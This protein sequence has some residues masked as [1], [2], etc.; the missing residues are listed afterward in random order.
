MGPEG[1]QK[2]AKSVLPKNRKPSPLPKFN[3]DTTEGPVL[4]I[5]HGANTLCQSIG[6]LLCAYCLIDILPF[7]PTSFVSFVRLQFL[8]M[9]AWPDS[10]IS[11]PS[12]RIA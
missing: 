11:G 12:T 2:A 6:A 10:G 1:G 9:G 5:L 3:T 8:C 7:L 4:K